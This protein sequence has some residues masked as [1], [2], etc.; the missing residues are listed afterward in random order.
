MTLNDLLPKTDFEILN[1]GDFDVELTKPFTCDL[2]SVCM[3]KASAGCL[4]V[5]V[6]GNT[7]AVAVASL[8]DTACIILAEDSKLDEIALMNAKT[9][10]VNILKSKLPIFETALKIYELLK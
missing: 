6:M 1:E 9:K 3:S 10:G 7:N 2:L 8:T 4:W 5:T